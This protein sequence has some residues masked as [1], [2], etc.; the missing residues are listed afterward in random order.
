VSVLGEL[1]P[2]VVRS[3]AA[4]PPRDSL[5]AAAVDVAG[6][7]SAACASAGEA[8]GVGSN[9]THPIPLK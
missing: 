4:R 6:A 8:A 7:R 3:A 1:G 2:S 9:V 5:M